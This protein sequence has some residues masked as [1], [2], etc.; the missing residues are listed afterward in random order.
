MSPLYPFAD[1]EIYHSLLNAK[2]SVTALNK[3]IFCEIFALDNDKLTCFEHEDITAYDIGNAGAKISSLADV[4]DYSAAMKRCINDKLLS[5]GV[6]II[7]PDHTFIGPDVLIDKGT[8]IYPNVIIEGKCQI[9]CDNMLMPNSYFSNVVIGDRN[10]IEGCYL[11]DCIVKDD[12]S[13]LNNATTVNLRGGITLISSH[14]YIGAGATLIA[15]VKIGEY[16]IVASGSTIDTDVRD[17]DMAISRLYQTNKRGYGYK[18]MNR[19]N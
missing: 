13:I 17:G 6:S 5:K 8:T 19:E 7:D 16:A 12:C 14:A 18:Y 3:G 9:G 2:G 1:Q 10:Y 15:P 11:K 4:A